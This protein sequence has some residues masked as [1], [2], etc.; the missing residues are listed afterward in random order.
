M[1]N[2]ANDDKEEGE[3]SDDDEIEGGLAKQD[4]RTKQSRDRCG[5]ESKRNPGFVDNH[6]SYDKYRYM[7]QNSQPPT[8]HS[9]NS[10]GHLLMHKSYD[11]QNDR[12]SHALQYD[13]IQVNPHY[14]RDSCLERERRDTRHYPDK[15]RRYNLQNQRGSHNV[16][17]GTSFY[18]SKTTPS[19]CILIVLLLLPLQL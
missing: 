9:G 2:C 5:D 11:S 4:M 7:L 10:S 3:L 14:S 18:A 6:D 15:L 13:R 12:P 1:E 17:D 19:K 16:E 8:F